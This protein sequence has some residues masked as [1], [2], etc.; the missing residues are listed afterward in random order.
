[1]SPP[2][3]SP[4]VLRKPGGSGIRIVRVKGIEDTKETKASKQNWSDAHMNLH[5]VWHL[6][7]NLNRSGTNGIL[8]LKAEVDTSHIQN[9]EAI[10]NR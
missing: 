5:I 4:L 9:P 7:Q 2:N 1:M 10:F 8:E 6:V 3:P